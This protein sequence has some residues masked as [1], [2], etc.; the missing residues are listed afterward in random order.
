MPSAPG[1]TFDRTFPGPAFPDHD[2]TAPDDGW[3]GASGTGS[4]T[5]QVAG[6]IA[7]LVQQAHLKGKVLTNDSVRDLLQ[8]TVVSV[9]RGQNSQ[10]FPAVGHPNIAVGFGLVNAGSAL[11][12]L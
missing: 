5:P 11:D 1:S 10:G 8:Q 9:E 6:L 7:L 2:E 12:R 4:A 3:F